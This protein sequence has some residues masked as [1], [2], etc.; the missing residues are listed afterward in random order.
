MLKVGFF[1]FVLFFVLGIE[2]RTFELAG[3]CLCFLAK[4]P[5]PVLKFSDPSASVSE[6]ASITAF[7]HPVL[8]FFLRVV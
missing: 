8:P 4:A 7:H 5:A 3:R 6:G 2:L 1:C